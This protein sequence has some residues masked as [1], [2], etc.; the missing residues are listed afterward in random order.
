MEERRMCDVGV[1]RNIDEVLAKAGLPPMENT[2]KPTL[3]SHRKPSK[4]TKPKTTKPRV[5][6]MK[7]EA[8]KDEAVK[9][10]RKPIPSMEFRLMF[11]DGN[12]PENDLDKR[13]KQTLREE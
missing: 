8:V 3:A 9:P 12:L 5:A 6:T 13:I 4:P 7:D 10:E 2:A 11:G 1:N